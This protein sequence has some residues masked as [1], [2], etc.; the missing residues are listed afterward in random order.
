MT[1]I[2][3][4]AALRRSLSSPVIN[5]FVC[6]FLGYL[7]EQCPPAES[8]NSGVLDAAVVTFAGTDWLLWDAIALDNGSWCQRKSGIWS[9][10]I[11]SHCGQAGKI[12]M[13][14]FI[15]EILHNTLVLLVFILRKKVECVIVELFLS[16]SLWMSL[17]TFSWHL[18]WRWVNHTNAVLRW[19]RGPHSTAKKFSYTWSMVF[20]KFS[21]WLH[22][23]KVHFA[24]SFLETSGR[25][26]TL[27][28]MYNGISMF[29]YLPLHI[30][31]IQTTL[32]SLIR[33]SQ[34][35]ETA[36]TQSWLWILKFKLGRCSLQ[37]PIPSWVFNHLFGLDHFLWWV[38]W[39]FW[40]SNII[41]E[42]HWT[43]RPEC[44]IV[45][46]DFDIIT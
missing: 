2:T 7:I 31:G 16:R 24:L 3:L 14:V 44:L 20:F 25:T 45:C 35:R 33:L 39:L 10:R 26:L 6:S 41:D 15:F 19:H 29:H 1:V 12:S 9:L 4:S 38:N 28:Q 46:F 40:I 27:D 34:V 42:S 21:S 13:I 43:Q 11:R 32:L 30:F 36:S 18:T 8:S 17:G 22:S 37:E 23:L 5:S